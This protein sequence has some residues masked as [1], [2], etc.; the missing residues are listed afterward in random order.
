MQSSV[1]V[2]PEATFIERHVYAAEDA[3]AFKQADPHI[4]NLLRSGPTHM[5]KVVN[6][7]GRLLPSRN[8][9]ERIAVK[10]EV[11]MR[12]GELIRRGQLRRIR[13]K[14][15]GLPTPRYMKVSPPSSPSGSVG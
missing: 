6:V 15:V 3:F 4:V 10:H 7:V 12:L 8:R 1:L 9:R 14:F 5:M 11:L 2:E 13:R